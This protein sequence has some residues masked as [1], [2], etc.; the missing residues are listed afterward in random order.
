MEKTVVKK[1]VNLRIRITKSR[2]SFLAKQNACG[3]RYY[4]LNLKDMNV[5]KITDC[6]GEVHEYVEFNEL[7]DR[8]NVIYS[9]REDDCARNKF[10]CLIAKCKKTL[11]FELE[12][13]D[14]IENRTI[15]IKID[16]KQY[17]YLIPISKLTNLFNKM[18]FK[19]SNQQLIEYNK[20]GNGFLV[21]PLISIESLDKNE[22]RCSYYNIKED[23][24]FYGDNIKLIEDEEENKN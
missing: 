1:R 6:C 24:Y 2:C 5:S 21:V 14:P 20:D 11:I 17:K 9:L 4:Y 3:D 12:E 19:Y 22:Y 18:N 23:R 8:V 15:D 13:T 7:Y 16:K 10:I